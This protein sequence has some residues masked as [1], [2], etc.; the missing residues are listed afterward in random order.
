MRF[1]SAAAAAAD[2]GADKT[3][4]KY[5]RLP[6]LLLPLPNIPSRI[7]GRG[8]CR[9]CPALCRGM[10][11]QMQSVP[12]CP[13]IA[14]LPAAENAE[15]LRPT[16]HEIA[17]APRSHSSAALRDSAGQV[18]IQNRDAGMLRGCSRAELFKG[19]VNPGRG[20]SGRSSWGIGR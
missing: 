13:V 19:E 2:K 3:M 1:P 7:P 10:P 14:R 17:A 4:L 5:L 9:R 11:G 6:V 12:H 8:R 20:C 16:S 18:F 15:W